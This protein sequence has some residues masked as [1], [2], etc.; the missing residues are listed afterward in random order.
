MRFT[1][2]QLWF[3]LLFLVSVGALQAGYW[4][5][6]KIIRRL[7]RLAPETWRRYTYFFGGRLRT[8]ALRRRIAMGGLG[9]EELGALLRRLKRL[10]TAAIGAFLVC[11]LLMAVFRI[12]R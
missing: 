9:D 12:G 3:I 11:I 2:S 7:R 10:N 6:R 5:E 8:G 1:P 4:I